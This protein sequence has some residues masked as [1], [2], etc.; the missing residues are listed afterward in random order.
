MTTGILSDNAVCGHTQSF[1]NWSKTPSPI[2]Y[3]LRFVAAQT[4][5]GSTLSV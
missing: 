5:P 3:L 4:R 1:I 2:C